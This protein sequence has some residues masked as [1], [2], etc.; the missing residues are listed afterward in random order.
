MTRG[1]RRYA[2]TVVAPAAC[3]LLA[4]PLASF[5]LGG[6]L[7]LLGAVTLTAG[8][9][10]FVL[11]IIR[12]ASTL[13][14]E[15]EALKRAETL[16][17]AS[18][19]RYRLLTE[20]VRD[21]V[22]RYD[23]DGVVEYVSPS[24]SQL[25]YSVHDWLGRTIYEFGHPDDLEARQSIRRM[26]FS[27]EASSATL[28]GEVRVRHADGHWVWLEGRP[29]ALRDEAGAVVAVL[30]VLRNVT[31]R[32]A[33]EAQL[34]QR[35]VE[36]EAAATAKSEFL[37]NMSHEIRTPL[38]AVVGFA[39]LLETMDGLP[40]E[41]RRYASRI[42]TSAEALVSVVNDIL[43]FSKLEAGQMT[44]DPH[45]FDP[46]ALIVSCADLV[47]DRAS[48]KGLT[49]EARF[50]GSPP[51]RL[52]AD[53][54]RLRQVLL[55]LLTNA[56]KFT[57]TGS[58]T[59]DAGY[60][61]ASMRLRVAV[62]DTGVGVPAE[63][64]NRLFRRFS[65]VDTSSARAA[66][67]TGLGLA[68]CKSLVEMMGGEICAES[69]TGVGSVFSFEVPAAPPVEDE[70]AVR[71]SPSPLEPAVTR[72]RILLVDDV[73]VNRELI[74]TMLSPFDL[75]IVEAGSGPDSVRV[76]MA[77][78][79]D[80]IL[81]DLQM[82]GMDGMAATKAIRVNSD[83]NRHTP[84]IAVSA[85]VLQDQVVAAHAAGMDDHIA[86]PI[87]PAELLS[88]IVKWTPPSAEASVREDAAA[89]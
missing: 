62:R 13:V 65:Q 54:A 87:D 37:A 39:G 86:K 59:I 60:D 84:I 73:A 74:S 35:S 70:E 19:A 79:F 18:E 64:A 25:G 7:N 22:I 23:R 55:N 78:R 44:L 71:S 1:V 83:L 72:A 50:A 26:V 61:R 27:G 57:E 6:P 40:A 80:L 88:K 17:S 21:L 41:A 63:R 8:A 34:E 30:T 4:L 16:L 47:R 58:I 67:G 5:A 56:V 15:N 68:I 49:L 43:D 89:A 53:G 76:A 82:P 48:G 38:T 77:S 45:P 51:P 2:F 52:V 33:L 14:R 75:D 11:F 42:A 29:S 66:G 36:A 10:A 81:M 46:Q 32:R 9:L 69:A 3:C 24:I 85:N 12:L 31:E 28:N 20:E